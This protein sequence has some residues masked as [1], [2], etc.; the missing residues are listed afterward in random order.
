MSNNDLLATI[1]RYFATFGRKP[2]TEIL[3]AYAL[4]LRGLSDA[5]VAAAF[6]AAVRKGTEHP[7]SAGQLLALGTLGGKDAG[8]AA[9]DAFNLLDKT[10][11]TGEYPLDY[12]DK[13][14]N[15]AVRELGGLQRLAE[16]PIK[17][18]Q[19]WTRKEFVAAYKRLLE[20]PPSDE[21]CKPLRGTLSA[22]HVLAN[23][24]RLG[25]V[26]AIRIGM[27]ETGKVVKQ[28]S[29]QPKDAPAI[30]GADLGLRLPTVE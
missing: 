23:K 14:I 20:N 8:A 13:L 6:T 4:T 22:D 26:G 7:L 25:D 2:D 11:G 21:Q 24:M 16:I 27:D 12:D 30:T 17:E 19:T 10:M 1:S 3:K 28:I 5:Q 9:E 29:A 18:F 15:A